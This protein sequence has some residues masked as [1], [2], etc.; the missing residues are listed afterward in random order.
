[1]IGP[2]LAGLLIGT[3]GSGWVFL[4]NAVTF[5]AV[6]GSLSA[7]RVRELHRKS[8]AGRTRGSVLDG[9]R[10]VRQRPELVTAVAM[11]FLIGTFALNFPIFIST[12]SVSVFHGGADEYGFLTAI[13][14]V[15]SIAGAL[16]SAGRMTPQ[17][18]L[19]FVATAVLGSGF[20]LAAIMPTYG[21]FG[22]AL[23]IV[24]VSAQIFTTNANSAVQ[25]ATEPAMRGRVMAILLA[26]AL[27]GTPVGAPLVGW[28][29]D[30][31]GPR[32]ALGVG[33]V[34]AFGAAGIALRHLTRHRRP[35]L[36]PPCPPS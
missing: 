12:M 20:A 1:M 13:M 22:V 34:S 32:W 14:A 17:V 30:T 8:P 21:L 10:Y 31:Y 11:F 35:D 36:S 27:G 15:G 3:V 5:A 29:A 33:A 4:I 9:F 25:L 28:V 16:L 18:P 23:V 24:G 19:L 26:V 7:L 6:I 2:A